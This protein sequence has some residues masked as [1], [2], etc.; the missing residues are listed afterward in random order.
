MVGGAVRDFF[1]GKTAEDLDVATNAT[2]QDVS[3]LFRKVVPTGIA[4]GTVTVFFKGRKI[5]CT[6]FRTE[7]GYSDSRHPDE[8]AFSASIEEDLARRDFTMNAIAVRLPDGEITDPFDGRGAIKRRTIKSVGDPV[9]R[10]SEDGLR[11]L[12]CVR[13]ACQTG[14]SVD[15]ETLAAIPSCLSVTAKVS[16]ERVRDEFIK[17]LRSPKPSLALRL[18]EGT[19]LLQLIL[20]ELAACRGIEQ[21]GF[22]HDDVLDHMLKACDAAYPSLTVRA[23]ALFHDIGKP[24]CRAWN[25]EKGRY[26]FYNHEKKSAEIAGEIMT[27]LRFPQKTVH[28]VRHLIELHMFH[29]E[30]SWTS[31]AVRRF[32]VKAGVENIP[33]LFKLR[34]AD[35][36]ATFSSGCDR[37]AATENPADAPIENEN[38]LLAEFEKRIEKELASAS[39]LSTKDLA[40]NGRD[41]IR[42]GIPAGPVMGKILDELFS[43]VLADPKNNEK[44][45]LLRIARA[46][47]QKLSVGGPHDP[48]AGRTE[49]PRTPHTRGKQ[50]M[51]ET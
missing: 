45:R 25:P 30:P 51:N 7:K 37:A 40:V 47:H 9:T 17:I 20:P 3:R 19:G 29:Y 44:E 41:L 24:S 12:R 27:R 32:I 35:S 8:I 26:T 22:H 48:H 34:A 11:P 36:H 1:L 38:A 28:S 23:A 15:E 4:H 33:D 16:R 6:T 43:T 5:E 21:L 46:Y 39:A 10:F 50:K 42:A 18:M 14:F 49:T 31:A 13:F 2:P